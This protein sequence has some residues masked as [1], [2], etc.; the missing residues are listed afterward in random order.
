MVSADRQD[1]SWQ[2]VDANLPEPMTPD[3]PRLAQ[4]LS[5]DAVDRLVRGAALRACNRYGV[6][7]QDRPDMRQ[8]AMIVVVDILT[9]PMTRAKARRLP[10][11]A[12]ATLALTQDR[13][14]ALTESADIAGISGASNVG[15]RRRGLF[16]HQAR[17]A[18]E[19]VQLAGKE[20]VEDYNAMIR[21]TRKDPDRSGAIATVADLESFR[22]GLVAGD[23]PW[24]AMAVGQ[25]S[26]TP[27]VLSDA[28]QVVSLAVAMA[29][30][31]PNADLET[32]MRA[33]LLPLAHGDV[34][35]READ[36]VE[37]TGLSRRAVRDAMGETIAILRDVM[38]RLG[39]TPAV[40]QAT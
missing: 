37:A 28:G 12:R 13:V 4:F 29:A 30:Q 21:A 31:H 33:Y 9:D 2:W 35:A 24:L 6:F 22:P 32:V 34:P 1:W 7:E 10:D 15:R 26:D 14:R 18:Q 40:A 36:I 27:W 20:L 25:A 16:S 3:D 19:G 17:R 11:I 5:T 38:T 23:E 39:L 8:E